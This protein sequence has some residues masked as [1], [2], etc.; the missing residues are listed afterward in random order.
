MSKVFIMG[1]VGA[2]NTGDEAILAGTLHTLRQRGVK[3]AS[4]FSWNPRETE[5]VHGVEALQVLPGVAGI[6]SFAAALNPGDLLLLGGGSLLQDG[7]RRIVPFWL[8]RALA[9]KARGCTVVFH[10]QGVGPLTT[11]LGKSLV[12]VVVPFAARLVTV[13]DPASADVMR[14]AR[15]MLVAD[16]ALALPALPR[17]KRQN[18]LVV[19]ALREWNYGREK[20]H[21][22]LWALQKL[23]SERGL[24]YAFLPMHRPDDVEMAEQYAQYCNGTVLSYSKLHELR[25]QLAQA[26]MVIAMRLHAAVLAAGVGTPVVG[27]SYD[28]KVA[29][30]FET[31]GISEASVPW[32]EH[33]DM[34]GFVALAGDVYQRREQQAVQLAAAVPSMRKRAEQSV[35]LALECWRKYSG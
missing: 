35:D 33:F 14:F 6:R 3:E 32:G 18:G 22:L 5:Q 15:P 31:M 23:A 1:F 29:A 8:S 9:A 28:P 11:V 13:R 12:R 17:V 4:V 27:L 19:V 24:K 34:T 20:E 7:E 21:E 30:F 2:G 16:P 10:A 26:E 25:Q